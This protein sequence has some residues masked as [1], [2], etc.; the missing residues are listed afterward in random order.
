MLTLYFS[1]TGNSKWIAGRFAQAMQSSCH[2]IEENLDYPALLA[3]HDTIAVVYPIYGSRVPLIMRQFA[4]RHSE[5]FAGKKLVILVTQLC[6]SGDGARAFVDLFP[7]KH[8]QPVYAAHFYM[9]NNVSNFALLQQTSAKSI[10]G[11]KRMA[12]KKIAAIAADLQAERVKLRGFSRFAQALGKI[13]GNKWPAMEAKAMHSVHVDEDCTGCGVCAK[14]CPMKNLTMQE[15]MPVQHDR[16][17][18]CLRCVNACPTRAIT[19][20]FRQKPKWQ[21]GGLSG[22]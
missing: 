18:V 14:I 11:R 10:A 6:F 12:E 13:Q 17:T 21:Y 7:P 5:H 8:M 22:E 19:V 9:P 1:G 16:C 15:R 4:Q 20:W 2:S 3:A